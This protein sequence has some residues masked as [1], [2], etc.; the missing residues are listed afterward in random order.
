[1]ESC[2]SS[3]TLFN[4]YMNEIIVKWN[5]IYAKGIALSTSTRVSTLLFGYDQFIIAHSENSL[6]RRV[7]A[8]QTIAKNFGMEISPEK[9]ETM[10]F[11]G[12]DPIRCKVVV[13]NKC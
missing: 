1:M 11:L 12:Q 7:F 2:P 3:P 6:H 8:L 4:I 13:D 5:Q 10:S 9:S